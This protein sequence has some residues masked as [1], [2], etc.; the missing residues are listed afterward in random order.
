MFD[1]DNIEIGIEIFWNILLQRDF[2]LF[3]TYT[4]HAF[5]LWS[6]RNHVPLGQIPS[7]NWAP[8]PEKSEKK[9]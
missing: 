2:I 5:C 9:H 6:I 8:S 1:A 4:N 3:T 7:Q